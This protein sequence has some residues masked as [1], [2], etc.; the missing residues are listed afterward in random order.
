MTI[1]YSATRNEFTEGLFAAIEKRVEGTVRWLE[2]NDG[3][4]VEV[5]LAM[6]K[7]TREQMQEM[8]RLKFIQTLSDG[9]DA[10]DV[11]AA[12]ELGI[13][14]SYAPG[15][16][17]G[18]S[19]S[20]AEYAVMLLLAASHKLNGAIARMRAGDSAKTV[21]PSLAGKTV[22][23]V[24]LGD[25]GAKVV[26]RLRAFEVRLLGVDRTPGKGPMDVPTRPLEELK[27][28]LGEADA[29]VICLRGSEENTHLF[30]AEMLDS[31]KAGA[32]LVNIARGSIV[33]ETALVTAVKRGRLLAGIDV[34][35]KEPAAKG[36]EMF[37]LPGM[38][39]TPH[40]A[41]MTD[42]NL[43][44]TAR[45]VGTVMKEY[46]EGKKVKSLLNEPEEPRGMVKG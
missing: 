28:A 21:S 29:V 7:V 46:A 13:Y 30:N 19:D 40:V 45:Y 32:V 18:N 11:K 44:G 27:T 41:G 16:E 43:E 34:L 24:G 33:E 5:L 36:S 2:K 22:L 14:V 23:V 42:I 20:V 6:G 12:T 25:I 26:A 38:F 4:E 1:G 35:E 8:P 3:A 15:E 9:Y 37:D 17:T 10:V 39:L 31:M